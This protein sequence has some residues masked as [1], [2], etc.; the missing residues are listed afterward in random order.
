MSGDSLDGGIEIT[1]RPRGKLSRSIRMMSGGERALTAISF[2][3]AIYL[4]KPSPFCIMDEVDAPLDDAN[5]DRFVKLLQQFERQTQL[6]VITH[7]KRSMEACE[8]LYG[9]TMEEPGVSKLVSVRLEHGELA[10]GEEVDAGD[11]GETSDDEPASGSTGE[12]A[13]LANGDGVRQVL[14][15]EAEPEPAGVG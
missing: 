14:D 1:A 12:P 10:E 3:F 6:I 11:T 15:D 4:V 8:R 9:V 5:I 7:N 2:L 13:T